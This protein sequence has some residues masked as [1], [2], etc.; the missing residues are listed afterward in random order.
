[1]LRG[2][3]FQREIV[4]RAVLS[5][6]KAAQKLDALARR[7]ATP[8]R[9]RDPWRAGRVKHVHVEAQINRTALQPFVQF[10][11]DVGKLARE[12]LPKGDDVIAKRSGFFERALDVGRAADANMIR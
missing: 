9:R 2:N 12:E 11:Q 6:D 5:T 4:N 3:S 8:T 1:M 7:Q 10:R